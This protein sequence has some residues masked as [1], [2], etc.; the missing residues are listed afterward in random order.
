M[1]LKQ[2]VPHFSIFLLVLASTAGAQDIDRKQ[3][4]WGHLAKYIGTYNYDAVL[5]DDEVSEKLTSILGDDLERLKRNLSVHGPIGFNGSCLILTGN[6]P[7][8]GFVENAYLNICLSRETVD[9]V[10]TDEDAIQI[11]SE[12][13]L[14]GHLDWMLRSWIFRF[15][16]EKH[17]TS[18]PVDISLI[19]TD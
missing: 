10:L 16:S 4:E 7:H 17:F 15:Q 14:F 5:S 1:Y 13:S 9:I 8:S 2:I 3:G 18:M 12:K 6:A 11:Y 19:Q